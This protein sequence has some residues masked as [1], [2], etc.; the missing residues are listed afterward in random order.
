MAQT[1]EPLLIK[2]LND[3][4]V[5]QSTLSCNPPAVSPSFG[6]VVTDQNI[7]CYTSDFKECIQIFLADLS[8]ISDLFQI[9]SEDM[10]IPR[11]RLRLRYIDSEGDHVIV[12]SRTRISEVAQYAIKLVVAENSR[13][14]P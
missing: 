9:V 1:A 11:D 2:R 10:D 13:L 14:V 3:E 12:S 6:L 4:P 8:S 5:V 7:K